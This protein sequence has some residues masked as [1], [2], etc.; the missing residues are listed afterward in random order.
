MKPNELSK[1]FDFS[2]RKKYDLMFDPSVEHLQNVNDAMY[3]GLFV[4]ACNDN[5]KDVF[6]YINVAILV[7]EKV[8][9]GEHSYIVR[10]LADLNTTYTVSTVKLLRDYERPVVLITDGTPRT[11]RVVGYKKDG[12]Y[13]SVKF[14]NSANQN[15]HFVMLEDVQ[16]IEVKE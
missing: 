3:Y 8:E 14:V 6:P 12:N 1:L 15:V 9:D 7:G 4:L 5:D 10:S 13:L 11:A 16:T 2:A